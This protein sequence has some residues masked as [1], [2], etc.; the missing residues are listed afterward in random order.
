MSI[1]YCV[2]LFFF[3]GSVFLKDP[4]NVCAETNGGL[5]VP[6]EE[7]VTLRCVVNN[8]GAIGVHVL[9]WNTPVS[10]FL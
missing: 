10:K 7:T 3:I 2:W 4:N 5:H 8:T 9:I 6:P 1:L